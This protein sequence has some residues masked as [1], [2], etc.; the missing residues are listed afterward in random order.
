M[1]TFLTQSMRKRSRHTSHQAKTGFYVAHVAG[2]EA[3]EDEFLLL[4]FGDSCEMA[5]AAGFML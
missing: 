3:H 4:A 5:S 1:F 2:L